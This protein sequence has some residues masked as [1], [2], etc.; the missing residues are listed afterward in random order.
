M[1]EVMSKDGTKIAFERSG[2]GPA[3]ILVSGASQDRSG[4]A[5]LAEILELNFTVFNYDRRGRGDSGDARPYAVEREIE[6]IGAVIEEAGGGPASVFGSSSGGNLALLA[7]AHGLP[8]LKLA[9]WEPNFIV[10]DARPPLPAD[11]VEQ[12]NEMVASDRRGDAVELFMTKAA[13]MPA[14]FVAPM[15]TM[16]MWPAMEAVA[17]TLAYDGAIVK[18]D[19]TGNPGAIARV[20]SVQVP[21][22]V[23]DGGTTPWMNHGAQAVAEAL[24][25]GRRRTLEGQPHNV[26]PDVLA[27]ALEEFFAG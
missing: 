27:P 8:I 6:D 4:N 19:M 5:T 17:H 15:R 22:L 21:T 16:P 12:I 24:P 20:V 23:M 2:G 7:A 3:V 25:N 10:D 9:L 13:G 14:E 26:D 18:D 1:Q 11:Y